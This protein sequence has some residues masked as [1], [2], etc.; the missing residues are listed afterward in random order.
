[1]CSCGCWYKQ[2]FGFKYY[3]SNHVARQRRKVNLVNLKTPA[4]RFIPAKF[5]SLSLFWCHHAFNSIY[6]SYVDVY[7][8]ANMFTCMTSKYWETTSRVGSD[9]L[10][11]TNTLMRKSEPRVR[12]T[13]FLYFYADPMPCVSGAWSMVSTRQQACG[14]VNASQKTK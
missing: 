7:L 14:T 13:V 6:P 1:M 10:A 12:Q 5:L 9:P 2:F 3:F 8:N 11:I 4:S